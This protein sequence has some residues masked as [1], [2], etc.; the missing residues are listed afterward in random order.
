MN[1]IAAIITFVAGMALAVA[2]SLICALPV[3]WLWNG[4]LV[5]AV[6]GVATIGWL[7][8]WGIVFL[9]SLLFKPS[10]KAK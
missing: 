2:L 9:C 10:I 7:Q 3:M 4:C 5:G 8:A 6:A 1:I